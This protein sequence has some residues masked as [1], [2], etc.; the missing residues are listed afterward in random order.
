MLKIINNSIPRPKTPPPIAAPS[1]PW[2]GNDAWWDHAR[3]QPGFEEPMPQQLRALSKA[4]YRPNYALFHAMGLGK[5][6]TAINL[7]AGRFITGQINMLIVICPTG[8]K[9]VW[10]DQIKWWCPCPTDV[11]VHEAGGN[12]DTE[13]FIASHTDKLK[14]LIFG[15]EAMSQ[16]AAHTFLNKAVMQSRCMIVLDESDTIK[17]HNKIRTKKITAAGESAKFKLIMTGTEVTQGIHDLYAQ[18]RFLH[19]KI[20]GHKSFFGFRATYC[21]MGGYQGKEIIGYLNSEELMARI[22]PFTDIVTKEEAM[23]WLP[24][25]TY[26]QRLVTPT[27]DQKRVMLDLKEMLMSEYKGREIEIETVL[28]RMTRYQQIVGGNYPY[29]TVDEK[30]NRA[31]ETRPFD[32][33]PKLGA[34]LEVVEEM[35]KDKIIIWA[36]FKP[37]LEAIA[38]ALAPLGRVVQFHG[39]VPKEDRKK[40]NDDF[41]F[42]DAQFMV[43]SQ[44]VGGVGQTWTAASKVIYYSNTFSYRDRMQSEDRCHRKGTKNPVLYVDITMNHPIDRLIVATLKNK[45]NIADYVKNELSKLQ[46]GG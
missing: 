28:E 13:L 34:L 27:P 11:H 40:A 21:V 39:G 42:G 7:A 5:T 9:L 25:K 41:Q 33:N 17:G 12:K 22:S 14:V 45:G 6:F 10:P 32:V 44:A 31:Y 1:P 46:N 23:P 20:I 30:G 37:E 29:E 35:G 15:V 19:W 16:G 18:F 4:W 3:K 43:A 8:V 2:E 24:P 38:K 26:E 36:R